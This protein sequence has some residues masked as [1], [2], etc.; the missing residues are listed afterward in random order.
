MGGVLLLT[1]S[2]AVGLWSQPSA[3]ARE[4]ILAA[5]LAVYAL[6]ARRY[7]KRFNVAI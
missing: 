7:W 2:V 4:L 1:P 3:P 6:H 5:S